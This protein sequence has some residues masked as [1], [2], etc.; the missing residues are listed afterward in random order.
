MSR[1]IVDKALNIV[2]ELLKWNRTDTLST[3]WRIG[4]KKYSDEQI[5]DAVVGFCEA[6]ESRYSMTPYEFMQYADPTGRKKAL[7]QIEKTRIENERS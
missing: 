6:G 3:I 5:Q 1:E 2:C 4:L 7:R